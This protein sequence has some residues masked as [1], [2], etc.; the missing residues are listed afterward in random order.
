MD[1]GVSVSQLLSPTFWPESI[2]ATGPGLSFQL[3]SRLSP[4]SIVKPCVHS[5]LISMPRL[6]KLEILAINKIV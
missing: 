2:K 5:S 1:M 4:G 3:D 6:Q